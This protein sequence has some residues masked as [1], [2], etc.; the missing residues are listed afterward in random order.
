MRSQIAQLELALALSKPPATPEARETEKQPDSDFDN[1]IPQLEQFDLD[2]RF[3]S[4]T[5]PVLQQLW[6]PANDPLY[7]LL[8]T[9]AAS[10]TIVVFALST[11]GW[12]HCA[13]RADDFLEQH[14][15]F[16]DALEAGYTV[17]EDQRPWLALWL[18]L[19]AAGLMYM[20]STFANRRKTRLAT[21]NI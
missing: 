13:V 3:D 5:N 10:Q 4:N 21:S 1:I 14:K 8:P 12:L 17:T 7:L 16:W 2:V 18:S 9:R 20:V 11:F 19:L 6:S 15:R